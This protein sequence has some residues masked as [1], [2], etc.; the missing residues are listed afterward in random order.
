MNKTGKIFI[1]GIFSMILGAFCGAVVW[2][3][4]RVMS[5]GMELLWET[6]PQTLGQEHSLVYNLAV[7]LI[8]GLLIGLW[9]KKY[10]VL[11]D[12]M[13]QVMG[14]VKKEGGYPYDRLHIIAVSAL[15]PLIFGG[16]LGPEAGLIGLIVGMCCFVGDKLKYKGDEVAALAEAG[17]AATVGVIFN[18]P[19]FGII[20][21][22]EQNNKTEQYRKKLVSKRARIW[23]YVMGVAGGMLAMAGFGRIFGGGSGLPRFESQHQYGWE[24]WKWFLLLIA[25]GVLF[26]M[27]YLCFEKATS[28]IAKRIAEHRILSCLI[29]GAAVAV[30]GYFLP[31]TMFSGEHEMGELMRQ[32]QTCSVVVLILTAIGK[33]LLVNV[34]INFGWRGGSIF[35]IIYS[36]VSL[37]YAMALVTGMDGAVAV[38]V[39]VAAVYAYIMRK[40]VTVVAVLLLCF[41]VT[42]IPAILISSIIA[43]KIPVPE[44]IAPHEG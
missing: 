12:D 39:T 27:L 8:G 38:A 2:V 30:I 21:N 14:R 25:A 33:L 43:S 18:A 16:A 28:V 23:I 29:A 34:C 44:I 5:I 22:L 3:V 26:G 10:G 36:G 37:G 1:F 41:P 20:D 6:L 40:P 19:L 17:M 35:P 42:Y 11:P 31:L 9:Q 24:Q 7:C 15:L 4:L 32:W 13:H